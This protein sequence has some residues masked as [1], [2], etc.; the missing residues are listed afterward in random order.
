MPLRYTKPPEGLAREL[1]E[2][3][4]DADALASAL[5]DG[6]NFDLPAEFPW[7][8]LRE[9][10][11][12]LAQL[13]N[14]TAEG[15]RVPLEYA[16]NRLPAIRRE[17]IPSEDSSESGSSSGSASPLTRDS[18]IDE[19]LRHL[20]ASTTTAFDEYRRL[21]SEAPREEP[22]PDAAR[23]VPD[24]LAQSAISQS[25]RLD[26]ELSAARKTVE[27]LSNPGSVGADN[28]KRQYQDTQQLNG[29]VRAELAMRRMVASW[30]RN[31]VKGLDKLPSVIRATTNGLR[32]GTDI[33]EIAAER[34]HDFSRNT[35]KAAIDE[36]RKTLDALE[37]VAIVLEN[38]RRG[39]L[40]GRQGVP[41]ETG[42]AQRAPE[43]RVPYNV[44]EQ[45]RAMILGGRAPPSH[46]VPFIRELNFYGKNL[47]SPKLLSGLTALQSLYLI[48]TPV[49]DVSPLSGLTALQSLYLSGTR[50][51]DVSPLSGLTALQSLDLTS[52][53]VSDVSPLSGLTA[54]Q[55][56]DLSSTRLS[57]VSP[58][59]GLTALQR[60]DLMGTPV[61]DVSALSGLTALQS[62]DLT[63]T[64]VSDVSPLSGLTALQR[65][66]LMGTP[67]SDLSPLSGLTALQSL[68][69]MG[70]QV[71][72]VSPLS[73]LTALQSLDLWATLVS[74]VSPLSGLT[75]LQSL[76]LRRTPVSDVSAL[77]G[78]T[79]LQ[80]LDLRRTPVSDV[81]PLS[82]LTALQ[83]LDLSDTNVTD[84]SMLEQI[85]GLKITGGPGS[86]R[87]T[88]PGRKPRPPR[89]TA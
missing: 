24:E 69:L 58:L 4:R 18:R 14:G 54:L 63:S 85:R 61:S 79:A 74:D 73:G 21:A 37:A 50:V 41:A 39:G 53:P 30:Y 26:A 52:T 15:C 83:R 82:G 68:Y 25:L 19:C 7:H 62:L 13:P 77:S 16:R 76:N 38:A 60:L 6:L 84:V 48:N 49:S 46:W 29:M 40:K 45:A 34:W 87:K 33:A 86:A 51:S 44:E 88:P 5:T 20:I 23:P 71:S 65:L 55:R 22:T 75:A 78:L 70:T 31:I 64:P 81:S 2:V 42:D 28:L 89:G 12:S 67:V 8:Q 80:S 32:I 1:R 35:T 59:S 57:D 17:H 27:E 72:D 36:I 10:C 9:I 11:R 47:D 43:P 56:L 3:A 66:D